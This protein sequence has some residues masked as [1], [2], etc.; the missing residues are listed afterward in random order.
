VER[1]A[2]TSAREAAAA[3]CRLARGAYR[4][5]EEAGEEG[6]V[7]GCGGAGGRH[8]AREANGRRPSAREAA[9]LLEGQTGGGRRAE[10]ERTGGAAG[11]W[12]GASEDGGEPGRA[13]DGGASARQRRPKS[14]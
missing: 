8:A 1:E 10:A 13:T 5:R 6:C 3:T 12:I 11:A 7:G 14:Q 9:A 2:A 4:R